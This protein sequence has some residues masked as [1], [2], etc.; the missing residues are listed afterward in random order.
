MQMLPGNDISLLHGW[1]PVTVEVV[2]AI[3]LGLAVGWRSRRWR[4]LWL[5]LAAVSGGV[6]AGAA[7]WSISAGLDGLPPP[8]GLYVWIALAGM[9]T[10]VTILGWRGARWW[11]R[12]VSIVAVPLCVLCSLLALNQWVGYF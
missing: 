6:A 5:P 8:S 2:T 9:A 10:A 12:S 3:A 7:H 4:L 11:R 1:A